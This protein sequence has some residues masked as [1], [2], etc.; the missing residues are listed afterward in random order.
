MVVYFY[1][2]TKSNGHFSNFYKSKFVISANVIGMSDEIEVACAEQAIMWLKALLMGDTNMAKTIAGETSP[3]KC[4]A[5]G[6]QVSPFDKV[7]WFEHR[8]KIAFEVV[9]L[10]FEDPTFK[11]ILLATNDE[12]IAEASAR[13][14]IWGIGIS[15][16]NAEKGMSWKGENILGKTLMLV[17][18]HVK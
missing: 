4:K 16:T 9:R 14:K 5:Y 18:N 8:N 2:H 17:R 11:K 13:D 12:I 7:K 10:K 6:R 3:V 15:V 1:G